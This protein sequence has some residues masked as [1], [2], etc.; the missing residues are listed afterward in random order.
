MVPPYDSCAGIAE[1]DVLPVIQIWVAE[2]LTRILVYG[3]L[4]LFVVGFFELD[5]Y[6]RGA[7]LLDE[8]KVEQAKEA[9]V[10]VRKI[11]KVKEIVRVPFIKKEIE[12]QQVFVEI[13]KEA[14]HVPDR[15]S[16]HLTLGWVH[17]HNAAV[18]ASGRAEG[19]V[20]DPTDS[21]ITEPEAAAVVVRNYKSF[22]QV[23]NNL[24]ACRAFVSGLSE[25]TK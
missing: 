19:A 12:I 25:A 15:I 24:V 8:Y 1:T 16:C 5:G 21:G 11:E 2:N 23:V 17:E 14:S 6:R 13:E 20:D 10:I 9:I 3:V 4:G 18:S 22:H 7:K